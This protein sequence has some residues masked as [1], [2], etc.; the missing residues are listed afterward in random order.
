MVSG[1]RREVKDYRLAW[2]QEYMVTGSQAIVFHKNGLHQAFTASSAGARYRHFDFCMR[3]FQKQ[4]WS[5]SCIPEISIHIVLILHPTQSLKSYR[6]DLS[7]V[8]TEEVVHD[9]CCRVE[10]S[11]FR[12]VQNK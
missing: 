4:L 5:T 9:K 2:I 8:P 7:S 11:R 6:K 1:S 3:W 10:Q 12:R